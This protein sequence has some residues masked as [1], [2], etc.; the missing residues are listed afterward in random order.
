MRNEKLYGRVLNWDDIPADSPRPGVKRRAYATDQVMLVL[1]ELQPDMQ[2]RP[3]THDDMDQ[4]VCV[5]SGRAL[6]YVDG[7]AHEMGPGSLLLVPAQAEHYIQ[8]LDGPVLNLDVFVP[9][10]SDYLHLVAYLDRLGEGREA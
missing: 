3:H 4:L 6:L 10:R 7:V 2:L 9:P 1:N 8:P 5:L